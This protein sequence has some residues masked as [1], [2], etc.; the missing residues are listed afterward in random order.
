MTQR[1]KEDL[2]AIRAATARLRVRTPAARAGRFSITQSVLRLQQSAGNSAVQRALLEA[3]RDAGASPAATEVVDAIGR[4][5]GG[6]QALE[7]T[8]RAD[9]EEALEMDLEG[10]RVHT[11]ATA[12][13]LS[14]SV[15]AQAFTTGKDVFF[16]SGA[17]APQ[18]APGREL[19]AHEL[20]HVVQQTGH[21]LHPKLV[22]GAAADEYE[23]EADRVATALVDRSA[24]T[25]EAAAQKGVPGVQRAEEDMPSQPAEE[26]EEESTGA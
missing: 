10:V 14:R 6:G 4:A 25:R 12:D 7:R 13:G 3:N 9:M 1:A 21:D 18:G 23:Q 19:L 8:L 17:Y 2:Q 11:D 24:T 5:R 26:E 15:N 20:T 22:V 16:R